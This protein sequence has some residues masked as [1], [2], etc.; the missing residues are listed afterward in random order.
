MKRLLI[1]MLLTVAAVPA[2]AA[3]RCYGPA[4]IDAER[5][6]RLHSEMMV[7]TVT[8]KQASTGRD[9][10]RAYTAFTRRHVNQIKEAETTMADYYASAY[11]G[12]GI[13][14]LDTLR[15]KLANEFGQLVADESAPAFCAQRRDMVVAMHDSPPSSLLEAGKL[16]YADSMSYAPTCGKSPKVAQTDSDEVLLATEPDPNP[17]AK[18]KKSKKKAKS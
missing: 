11:G 9:L 5:V 1:A 4:E 13:S 12:D 17:A 2:H 8:C 3:S 10:V 16:L 7:V 15:T 18:P 6:L 14:R